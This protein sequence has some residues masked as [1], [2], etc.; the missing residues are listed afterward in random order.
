MSV[1]SMLREARKSLGLGEPNHIQRW[2]ARRNGSAYNYNFAW[3]DA[4]VTYWA[5]HSG[6][7]DAVCPQGD[8]AYT[9][10]H[11]QDFQRL[12]RWHAGTSASVRRARP[13]DIVFFDWSGSNSVG[14]I[15]HVG[16]VERNLGGGRLQTIEGNTS[17]RCLR[18]VRSS[19][20][21]AGFGRPAYS[22]SSDGGSGDGLLRRGDAGA[23]VRRLQDLLNEHNYELTV[24][25]IYGPRTEAAVRAYQRAN[26]LQVDG[27]AGPQ[28]M[29]H[30][31]EDDMPSAEEIAK[32]VT[33]GR[34]IELELGGK[35]QSRNLSYALRHLER[36]QDAN[37]ARLEAQSAT[38]DKLVD[39]VA[40]GP[41][42]DVE[43]LKAEIREAIESVSVRLDVEDEQT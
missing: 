35:R 40:A 15:D 25:G 38:I 16:V 37:A 24:D 6:N 42:V 27:I 31:Q 14:R 3:C 39:A 36:Q 33:G 41:G 7:H 34:Y 11:A 22:G 43:A 12:G 5:A 32:E 1:A 2:Y 29:T 28:T 13:G 21:I 10:W 8:R 9:V 4:A 20:V 26:G 30:L 17:N 19:G 23:A 18:R